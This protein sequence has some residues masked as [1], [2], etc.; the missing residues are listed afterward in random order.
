MSFSNA[1]PKHLRPFREKILALRKA[2]RT[3]AT[4]VCV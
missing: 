4:P 1:L 2:F 3:T